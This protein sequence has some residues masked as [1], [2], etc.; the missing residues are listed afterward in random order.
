MENERQKIL[1]EI[2]RGIIRSTAVPPHAKHPTLDLKT[3]LGKEAA[4]YVRKLPDRADYR[5]DVH[6]LLVHMPCA[7]VPTHRL[8][9]VG[10]IRLGALGEEGL[11]E[12]IPLGQTSRTAIQV[13]HMLLDHSVRAGVLQCVWRLRDHVPV[14]G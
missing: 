10:A 1:D 11:V 7:E 14:E 4:E 9:R 5:A 2:A 3:I 13:P 8:Y 6:D 12:L